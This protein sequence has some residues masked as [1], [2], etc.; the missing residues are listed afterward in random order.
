MYNH[1]CKKCLYEWKSNLE[2]PKSCP[3]CKRYDWDKERFYKRGVKN[4]KQTE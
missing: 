3:N 4:D 1:K 2:R